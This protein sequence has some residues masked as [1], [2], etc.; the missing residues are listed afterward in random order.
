[1]S[2]RSKDQSQL[3]YNLRNGLWLVVLIIMSGSFI[4]SVPGQS[5]KSPPKTRTDNVKETI[6]GVEI[7]DPYRWL[8]DQKS[9]E[10][11]A[12]IDAQ[13]RFARSY[14]D[15]LPDRAEIRAKLTGLLKIDSVLPPVARQGKYFFL[16]RIPKVQVSVRLAAANEHSNDR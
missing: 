6:H 11:R 3:L 7:A 13:S 12:W 10:T 16:V 1:M 4:G 5:H 2:R 15:A 14:L 8:E 9:P